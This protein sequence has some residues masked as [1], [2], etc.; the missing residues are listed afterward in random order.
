MNTATKSN[1]AGVLVSSWGS[2]LCKTAVK[3]LLLTNRQ[4]V[5]VSCYFQLASLFKKE[6]IYSFIQGL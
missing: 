4:K 6:N 1:M 5:Q 3:L 2:S